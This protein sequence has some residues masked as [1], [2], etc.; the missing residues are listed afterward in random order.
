MQIIGKQVV[1]FMTIEH[2]I[3]EV[4]EDSI[5]YELEIEPGDV[6]LKINDKEKMYKMNI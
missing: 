3:K 6:L 4:S 2:V 5:A 1:F